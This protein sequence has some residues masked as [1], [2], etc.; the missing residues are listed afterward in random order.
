MQTNIENFK[1]LSI[2]QIYS[3]LRPVILKCYSSFKY[4]GISSEE[5]NEIVVKEIAFTKDVCKE[6]QKFEE[7]LQKRIN[8]QLTGKVKQKLN[9]SETEF[10][11]LNNYINQKF[12]KI[13]DY[14]D[15]M[16][17]FKNLNTFVESYSYVPSPDIL[18]ELINKNA[19]FKSMIEIVFKKSSK[20]IMQGKA[21]IL[22]DNNLLLLTIDSYCM[23]YNIE[24]D[25]QDDYFNN[26]SSKEVVDSTG[27]YFKEI[28]KMPLLTI[29]EEKELA[30]R[31]SM[32]DN[33]AKKKFIECNLKLVASVAKRYNVRGLTIDDLIQEGNI[34]LMIAV[35]KYDASK[36]Y[37]FST[38]AAYW[39]KQAITRAIDD[40][41]RNIR[42]PVYLA[43][44][45]NEYRKTSLKLESKLGR[46][47]TTS[48]IANE[49]KLSLPEVIKLIKV[50]DDTISINAP[51]GEDEDDELG[52]FLP[53]EN[54]TP[55]ETVISETLPTQIKELFE[56][57]KL[58]PREIE[59]L[60]YRFGISNENGEPMTLEQV[61][62]K[63][64]L[65]R[66][67]VRQLEAKALIKIRKSAYAEELAEYTDNPEKSLQTLKRFRERYRRDRT[68]YKIYLRNDGRSKR[69]LKSNEMSK[70]ET[71]YQ[72]FEN[73]TKEQINEMLKKLTAE[74][75]ELV[76]IR[77][78]EFLNYPKSAILTDEEAY[79]YYD[80][81]V[82]KMKKIL[83]NSVTKALSS[84]KE[85]KNINI[86]KALEDPLFVENLRT[87]STR[88]AIDKLFK[89][90]DF[91]ID[92][93]LIRL[94]SKAL[95]KRKDEVRNT[96]KEVLRSYK[97]NLNNNENID[98]SSEIS[99]QIKKLTFDKK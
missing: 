84:K 42:I 61:G 57:C 25:E 5:F 17:K 39:I 43:A 13:S 32:G 15:V 81:L 93:V 45:Y 10:E 26:M 73:Y 82:P 94:I 96:M 6:N 41:S 92:T 1:E 23:L 33:E 31:V 55:E 18:I 88:D 83:D 8:Q 91:E 98:K 3:T 70:V 86:K 38:Y 69:F 29:D 44:K 34:G 9:N 75:K 85:D 22:F 77:Y 56:K 14:K 60:M 24:I 7:L 78:G 95:G 65:T 40:K 62:Q 74:E 76:K 49:M 28:S 52:N 30:K 46:T 64:N 4:A 80:V 67:R 90:G 50:Q 19:T 16:K 12:G 63:Y 71:I 53:S 2:R 99:E 47:P 20:Q 48:E 66:E 89:M 68:T 97:E 36:G 27:I 37:K 35:D 51:T 54:K 58:K 11:V 21:D 87:L 59:V 72:Y 79:Q